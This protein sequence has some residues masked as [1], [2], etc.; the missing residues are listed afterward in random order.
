MEKIA[1]QGLLYDFYGALLTEHQRHVYEDVV[2]YDLSLSEIA[3]EQ[4][5]SRQGVHDLIKRC[6]KILEGYE[7]KLHLMEKFEQTKKLAREIQSL[8]KE[9]SVSR[10][11]DLIHRI[12]EISGEIIE[13]EAH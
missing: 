2:F 9:L 10:N 7:E 13:L 8:T 6:D 11:M 3:E 5:I 12:E 1:R 4:G